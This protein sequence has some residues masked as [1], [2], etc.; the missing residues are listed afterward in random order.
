MTTRLKAV[1]VGA[2]VIAAVGFATVAS[3]SSGSDGSDAPKP[4]PRIVKARAAQ[5]G[6]P[7]TGNTV[8]LNPGENLTS[9]AT[10]PAGTAPTGGGG[11]TSSY[12]IFFTDSYASG[13]TWILRGTNKGSGPQNLTAF[14]LCQ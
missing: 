9:S 13:S 14:A 12:D 7:V 6:S 8:T 2:A 4:K 5:A 11:T 10:C 3:A 1:S